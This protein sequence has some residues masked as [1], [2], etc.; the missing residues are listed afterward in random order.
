MS[1]PDWIS[2]GDEAPD[3]DETVLVAMP[4]GAEPVFLGYKDGDAWRSVH[5]ERV[6]VSHWMRL[7]DPPEVEP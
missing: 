7:P 2:V 4:R 6:M 5:G 1:A 3:D